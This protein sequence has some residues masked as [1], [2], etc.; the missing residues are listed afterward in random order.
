MLEHHNGLAVD[1]AP[2]FEVQ[3]GHRAL[4]D[5]AG[6]DLEVEGRRDALV[7]LVDRVELDTEPGGELG[8]DR[9]PGKRGDTGLEE[10]GYMVHRL[11]ESHDVEEHLGLVVGGVIQ[12]LVAADLIDVL[13]DTGDHQ[14]E[15]VIAEAGIDPI[16][17][18]R[19]TTSEG[20][21]DHG[22]G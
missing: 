4:L 19:G 9:P 10:H 21:V 18:D 22:L 12:D 8:D 1:H 20:G 6:I 7:P 5:W 2:Q 3:T 15:L 13:R 16:D 11:G 17:E 14:W